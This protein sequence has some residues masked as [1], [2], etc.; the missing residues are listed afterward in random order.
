VACDQLDN[1]TRAFFQ[2]LDTLDLHLPEV[3]ASFAPFRDARIY[4]QSDN[5]HYSANAG[6]D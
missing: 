1:L 3:L 2:V 5:G 6:S 4:N